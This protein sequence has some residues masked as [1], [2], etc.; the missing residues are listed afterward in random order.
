MPLNRLT[1]VL[2]DH[3]SNLEE[4]GTAK[5]AESVVTKAIPPAG[6]R[7]PRFHLEGEGEKE[8][9]RMNSNSYLGMSLRPEIMR[10]GGRGHSPL[11]C[12]PRRGPLHQ[13]HLRCPYPARGGFGSHSTAGKMP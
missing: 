1:E 9:L 6:D 8:F 3:V 7:G 12:R 4:K 10:A 13:R 2:R 5:G 11:R